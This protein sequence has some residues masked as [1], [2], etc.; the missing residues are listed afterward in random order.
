MLKLL[1]RNLINI[2]GWK[3]ERKLIIFESDDWGSIRMPSKSVFDDLKEKGY[4]PQNDYYLKYD[5]LESNEDLKLL[6][7]VLES[8]KDKNGNS[9]VLTAN[10][11]VA[12]PD[13]DKIR[14]NNFQN[15]I[16]ETFTETLKKYPNHDKVY[17]LWKFGIKKKIF[18]P[19]FHGREHLNVA[20]WMLSLQQKNPDIMTAFD[21]KMLSVSSISSKMKFGFMEGLDY[22]SEVERLSKPQILEDG[23]KI[24]ENLIGYK[25]KTFIANCYIWD[26]LVEKKMSDLEVKN[27]QTIL[28]QMEPQINNKRH[29]FKYKKHFTGQKN[30]FNQK[31]TIRNAF[32]EPSLNPDMD[33][34]NECLNRI[35]IAFRWKKPAIICTHRLNFIGGIHPENREKNLELFSILLNKI[36]SKWKDIEFISSSELVEIMDKN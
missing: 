29:Y 16:Y 13:F 3:T 7:D 20:Q 33:W 4:F 35:E 9:A 2:P 22:F 36:C 1:K 31:Y 34:V 32:F 12:N 6:F 27:I 30:K 25:S 5:C 28:N 14:Q 18:I 21:N 15:Y 10:V 8:V 23:M 17:E 24:F 19:Q 11:I 26:D